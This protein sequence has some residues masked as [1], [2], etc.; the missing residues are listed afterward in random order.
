VDSISLYTLENIKD[1]PC[2][3]QYYGTDEE[4]MEEFEILKKMILD[5]GYRRYEISNFAKSSKTSIHNMV[6]R[7]MEPY[8]GLW[9]SAS[10]FFWN[11]RRTN[12]GDIKQYLEWKRF[13]EQQVQT[14]NESDLLI[15]EFF[16]RL[17]T[18]SW[19]AD[20]S[21]F[22]SVLVPNYEWLITNYELAGLVAFDG[23]KLQLRDSGMNVYNT[24]VTDLLRNV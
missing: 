8:I 18:S 10:S 22:T 14:M 16:L 20:I 5:A 3:K 15:E 19:I 1:K 6:Y 17:R 4:I 11:K 12:T 13:D 7:N 23:T 21:K 24:I 2:P 9:L